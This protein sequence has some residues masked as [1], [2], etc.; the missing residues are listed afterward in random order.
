M[1]F[2]N[3]FLC[4]FIFLKF[5]FTSLV[6]YPKNFMFYYKLGLIILPPID[7]DHVRFVERDQV[8]VKIFNFVDCCVIEIRHGAHLDHVTGVN[9]YLRLDYFLFTYSETCVQRPSS[10]GA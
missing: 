10:L 8:F 1:H 6:N 3:N 2:L 5:A 9:G 7:I 4:N